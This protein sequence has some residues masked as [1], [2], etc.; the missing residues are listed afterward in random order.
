A[1]GD[2]KFIRCIAG[3]NA[4]RDVRLQ[5]LLKPLG[6]LARS[7]IFALATGERRIVDSKHHVQGRLIDMYALHRNRILDGSNGVTD[8]E[9]LQAFDGTEV[10]HFDLLD[11][12]ASQSLESQEFLHTRLSD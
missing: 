8:V 6:D 3:G 9:L 12:R 2:I 5:F 11:S 7:D 4:K 10:P 1:A